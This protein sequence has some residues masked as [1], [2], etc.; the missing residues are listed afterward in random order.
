MSGRGNIDLISLDTQPLVRL[1][2]Y[3]ISF[4]FHTKIIFKVLTTNQDSLF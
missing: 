4:L 2:K 1:F 3:F